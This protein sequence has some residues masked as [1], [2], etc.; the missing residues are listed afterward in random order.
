VPDYNKLFD[1]IQRHYK[2]LIPFL[3]VRKAANIIKA[4]AEMQMG[5]ITCS[6]RPFVYKLEPCSLC[7]L[8][9]V[10]CSLT[11]R[12]QVIREKRIMDL[13]DFTSI[14]DRVRRHAIRASLSEQGEPLLNRD[15]YRMI[16]YAAAHRI[17][18]SISTNFNHY[19][20]DALLDSRLTLL[21]PCLDGFTQA[22]YEQYRK[23]G[24]VEKVKTGIKLVIER[25][26]QLR[27][28]YPIVDV[29]VVLFDHVQKERHL[30]DT[31]LAECGV[32][33]VTYRPEI[34]GFNAPETQWQP[35][36]KERCF[37][38]YIA[39]MIKPDG[40]VLPCCGKGFDAFS[41][42]NILHQDISEIWNNRFYRFS[43]ALFIEGP[44]LPFDEE[45]EQIP[46]LT[47]T[48]FTRSRNMTAS[49]G[50]PMT[51]W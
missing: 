40:S 20:I 46:C 8:R 49:P 23:G 50:Q 16:S 13:E 18:I 5:R 27:L 29:N 10:S 33:K 15:I 14:I 12:K 3:D 1:F 6:S 51:M 48:M 41:Y 35:P 39:M 24:D 2:T 42:G 36:R 11:N 19:D 9:C 37:W 30:I 4:L 32:D 28:R 45:M 43:R 44:D 47:C 38:L 7:N 22:C 25:R 26:N 17:S 21:E 34:A 31:F